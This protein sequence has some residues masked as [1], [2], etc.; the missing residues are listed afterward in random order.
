M[1]FNFHKQKN[2]P[3]GGNQYGTPQKKDRI[4]EYFRW[5]AKIPKNYAVSFW[6]CGTDDFDRHHLCL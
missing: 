5:L 4:R 6:Y 1:N 2:I 3:N